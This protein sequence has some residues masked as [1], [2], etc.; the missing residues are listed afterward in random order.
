MYDDDN[1]PDGFDETALAR[2]VRLH[3]WRRLFGYARPYRRDVTRLAVF[4]FLVACA[5]I[6]FPLITKS[7]VDAVAKHGRNANLWPY[8]G[9]YLACSL[10]LAGS[11]GGFVWAGGKLSTHLGH[12]IRQ[13][14]F[15]NV[16]RL[17][18]AFFD[19]RPV[20]WLV[21]RMTSDCERLSA[22][23]TWSFLDSVWG[24]TV[25]LGV[26]L[27]MLAINAKLCLYILAVVPL[28]AWLSGR[29]QKRILSSARTVRRTNSRLTAAYSEGITGVLTSKAFVR[30]EH[31]LHDFQALTSQM[32]SASVR[33]TTL[34]A[35]YLPMVLTLT[36]LATGVT[37]AMGGY[38]VLHGTISAGTLVAFMAYART[39]FDPVE[40]LGRRFVE[41]QMAQVSAERVF[42]LIDAVPAISDSAAVR[43]AIAKSAA[44]PVPPE[45]APDGGPATIERIEL[46][47]VSFAYDGA[48]PVLDHVSLQVARGETIAIVGPTG[49]GKSTLVN[50]ICR[51]Y[52]P[53]AGRVLINGADYRQRSLEWLHGNLG[54]V[55]Q[56]AHLFSGS[57]MENIR[58]GRL[59]A[60]DAEVIECAKLVG[61]HDFV[62][63]MEQQYAT[64]VGEGGSRL[65]AGQKQ[66]V[67]FAR[68]ILADPQIL[69]M[70]EA[71]ASVDTE[72]ERWIQ[73]G[74]AR[75]LTGR[76]AFVI[77]HRLSTI[78]QATRILVVESGRISEAGTHAELMAARGHYYELYRQQS[79]QQ[80]THT[81]VADRATG[82][83]EGVA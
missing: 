10:L 63:Q 42:S 61:V 4:G 23:L 67:S 38:D 35:L 31:N 82:L 83:V 32:F 72:T 77:A 59:D 62:M 9:A 45:V 33:N 60:S 6:A 20:G 34:A 47:D 36:S 30:E 14:A 64:E 73:R 56:S 25:M 5:D 55:L 18:F 58:F 44:T 66:L 71:T 69:V 19:H 43:A 24:A 53:T 21:A 17:S 1:Q 26:V 27:S 40:Q 16:Q 52:E 41:L 50:L 2:G 39:L 46:D 68:A 13:A 37:L 74:L 15:E 12:D 78:R 75:V 51:F 54:M 8:A 49:G 76:I 81:L 11:I 65:S 3:L 28:L 80:A 7:V 48:R 29:F 22:N 57:L 70:D 79:L